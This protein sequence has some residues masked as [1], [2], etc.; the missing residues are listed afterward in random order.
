MS[1]TSEVVACYFCG[2]EEKADYVCPDGHYTCEECRLASPDEL[3][4]RVCRASAETDPMKIATLLMKHPAIPIHG[5]EHHYLVSSVL[6]A[7][8]KNLGRPRIENTSF[9]DAVRRAKR[10]AYGSCGLWGICGAAAGAG[11]A[12][13]I[14]TGA[15][16][17]SDKERSQAMQVVSE[18]LEE[19]AKIGGPRCCK[20][21]TFTAIKSA[22]RFLKEKLGIPFPP[23][24]DPKPCE[25]ADLNKECLKEKCSYFR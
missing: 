9:D 19:I 15:N 1:P 13:S 20:A 4:K 5:P 10:I 6:L 3:V 21:S 11:I 24:K 22:V 16:M 2:K 8:I 18:A 12:T 23:S 25:F 14:L 7:A 17:M